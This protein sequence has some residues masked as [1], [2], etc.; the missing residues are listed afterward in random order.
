MERVIGILLFLLLASLYA[1]SYLSFSELV[2]LS[3]WLIAGFAIVRY[4]LKP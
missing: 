4:L 3:L 1:F 2:I